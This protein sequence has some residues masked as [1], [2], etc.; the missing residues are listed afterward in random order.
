MYI[1]RRPFD[2]HSQFTHSNW[3][4]HLRPIAALNDVQPPLLVW[5]DPPRSDMHYGEVFLFSVWPLRR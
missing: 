2:N 3:R 5:R 4:E 1:M